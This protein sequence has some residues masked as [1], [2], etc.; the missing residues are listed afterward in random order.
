LPISRF[1]RSRLSDY[2]RFSFSL[3]DFDFGFL[4]FIFLHVLRLFFIFLDYSPLSLL[5]FFR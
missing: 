5:F 4:R 1:R 2:F 3:P